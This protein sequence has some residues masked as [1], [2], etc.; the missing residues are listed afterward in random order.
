MVSRTFLGTLLW[1]SLAYTFCGYVMPPELDWHPRESRDHICILMCPEL[2]QNTWHRTQKNGSSRAADPEIGSRCDSSTLSSPDMAGAGCFP[3]QW[4]QE[5][6]V[7]SASSP[8]RDTKMKSGKWAGADERPE[9]CVKYTNGRKGW[10]WQQGWELARGFSLFH[11]SCQ[12]R[13]WEH[14]WGKKMDFQESEQ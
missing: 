4:G 3:G 1:C 9:R 10:K 7:V 12:G 5:N 11:A 13:S 6:T 14:S 2:Q 8:P